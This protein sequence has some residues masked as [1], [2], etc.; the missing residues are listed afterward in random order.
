MKCAV[1]ERDQCFGWNP[2]RIK[3]ARVGHE[4][5]I[6]R[7]SKS[8]LS[9]RI[10]KRESLF[11]GLPPFGDASFG[12]DVAEEPILFRWLEAIGDL[13]ITW[14]IHLHIFGVVRPVLCRHRF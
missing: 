7:E 5:I 8:L 2:Q 12:I 11:K 9:L 14:A 3:Q 13:V 4:L 1:V 10:F 6:P